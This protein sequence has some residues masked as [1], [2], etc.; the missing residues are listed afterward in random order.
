MAQNQ[1]RPSPSSDRAA[2]QAALRENRDLRRQLG[3]RDEVIAL[4]RRQIA[5]Q[6]ARI[7]QLEGMVEELRRA[8]KRQAAPFSKGPP[9]ENPKRPG[10]KPGARYGIQS[11]RPPPKPGEVQERYPAKLPAQSP[12]CHAK[13][14]AVTGKT[15][16]QFQD[17]LV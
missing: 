9:K 16:P 12:C 15:V 1:V 10:R 13:V 6:Q 7:L 8:Q 3:E 14:K 11:S 5:Q 2:L 17:E 4:L